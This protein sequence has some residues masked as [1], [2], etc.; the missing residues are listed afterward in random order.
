[1]ISFRKKIFITFVVIYIILIALMFPFG[2]HTV[3]SIV[4]MGMEDR[5]NEMIER[6]QH[7]KDDDALIKLLKDQKSLIFFRVS[8]ISDEYK[9]LYDSHT[10][11][12]IGP[13]FSQDNVVNHPEVIDA[14]ENGIGYNEDYSELMG[15]KF[16]YLAKVFDFH[17]KKYVL[18]TAFP[19]KYVVQMTNDFEKGF[20]VVS[21]AVL[22]L[23][24]LLT[25]WMINRITTPINKIIDAVRPY[26]EGVVT[27]IP[28]VQTLRMDGEDEFG[29]LAQ[30]LN[31]LSEKIQKQI[32]TLTFEKNEKAATLEA[33][34]EGVIAV[35]D[36]MT[37]TYVNHTAEEFL[38]LQNLVGKTFDP[39]IEPLC[40]NLLRQCQQNQKILT[41]TLKLKKDHGK[42]LYNILAVPKANR[43]GAVLVLQD[44]SALFK[45]LEMKKDFIANASHELKTPITIVRGFAEMLHENPDLPVETRGDMTEKIVRNCVRMTSLIKDLLTLSD[46]ENIPESRLIDCDIHSVVQN[47]ANLLRDAFPTANI[48]IEH[49]DNIVYHIKADPTLMEMAFMNLIE[50]GIKYSTP[51]ADIKITFE[52]ISPHKL[53]IKVTDKGIGIPEIDVEHIFERFYTVDK[54]H[55]QKMGGSGL[56]LSIVENTIIKHGGTIRLESKVGEGTTFFIQFPLTN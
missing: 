5:A 43:S 10:K 46:V 4:N 14:F 19:Y 37:I 2:A 50:N 22:L 27:T 17:D 39:S 49:P 36:K 16:V 26:Q 33:L 34:I 20:F 51:P 40:D 35:D 41:D 13:Q 11:R 6:I 24:G 52:T 32:D 23:F 42:F 9:V 53:L 38:G 25:W 12:I 3:R 8:V 47:C 1:M 15:E 56:G 30:T 45:V 31:S 44:Q 28:T 18:R 48:V 21:S 7:A 55:S 29:K 54:A